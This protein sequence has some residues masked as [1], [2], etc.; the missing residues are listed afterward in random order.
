MNITTAITQIVAPSRQRSGVATQHRDAPQPVG[1][2]FQREHWLWNDAGL[3]REGFRYAFRGLV[4]M[5]LR[6]RAKHIAP[7]LLDLTAERR[8]GPD[9]SE[10]VEEDHPWTRLLARPNPDLSP[11]ELWKWAV[12]N[13][14]AA[15]H[16]DFLV[17][18]S[19]LDTPGVSGEVPSALVPLYPAWGRLV[20]VY[21]GWG[22]E[23]AWVLHRS[24]G[25]QFRVEPENVLRIKRG[26]PVSPA[27]TAGLIEAAAFE[28]Q[29]DRAANIF[30]RDSLQAQ[31]LPDVMLEVEEEYDRATVQRLASD[32][33]S[34]F[35][36]AGRAKKGLVPA[37]HGGMRIKQM[38]LSKSD[39]EFMAQRQFLRD[40]LFYLFEVH[41]GLFA[42]NS[43][44]ANAKQAPRSFEMQTVQ[45]EVD[46]YAAKLGHALERLFDA[47]R[48]ALFVSPPN[49]VSVDEEQQA[50]IDKTRIESGT[51]TRNE[52]RRRDGMEDLDGG[53]IA[54]VRATLV[55]APSSQNGSNDDETQSENTSDGEESG[56]GS[57]SGRTTGA[58]RMVGDR[59][60]NR[61]LTAD[62]ID[63]ARTEAEAQLREELMAVLMAHG[64]RVSEALSGAETAEDALALASGVAVG[65]A[66]EDAV[67]DAY[68]RLVA[69]FGAA[70]A[71]VFAEELG[72]ELSDVDWGDVASGLAAEVEAAGI[73]AQMKSTTRT[74][75]VGVA[76]ALAE[77]LEDEVEELG[78]ELS[79]QFIPAIRARVGR[80]VGGTAANPGVAG[81]EAGRA[82]NAGMEA[83]TES[84]AEDV[85]GGAEYTWNNWGDSRVR[86]TH[87]AAGGQTRGEGETFTVGGETCRY[88]CDP[89]LSAKESVNCRCWLTASVITDSEED[90]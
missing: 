75:A 62:D 10:P 71:D 22:A 73:F 6:Y 19:R 56:Q 85:G 81:T 83:A 41:Q 47:D 37:S 84:A 78:E 4:A 42:Q 72:E 14:D 40:T 28:I 21:D 25:Q 9:E 65:D 20:P 18:R 55:P 27:R 38:Q 12:M 15:G 64:G 24:D 53:D 44:E 54:L 8:L 68:A 58:S 74:D 33:A 13:V 88:P 29:Q 51:R 89:Q 3:S 1:A 60:G 77:D 43:T 82:M 7:P 46:A 36:A 67:R 30:A 35:Q 16:A 26:H 57:S 76:V 69:Q 31:G 61:Q 34:T 49:V 45:P 32:F 87:V 50:A 17:R 63:P 59:R 90:E 66:L 48:G 11:F 80:R 23:Q 70:Q 2:V 86:L 52:V 39:E 5:L 79:R